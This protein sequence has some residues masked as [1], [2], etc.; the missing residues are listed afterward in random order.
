MCF[1]L[2]LFIDVPHL[3]CR[4]H[5]DGGLN[6]ANFMSKKTVLV[7]LGRSSYA[8]CITNECIQAHCNDLVAAKAALL[9]TDDCENR[10]GSNRCAYFPV[11]WQ[12]HLMPNDEFYTSE[13][14]TICQDCFLAQQVAQQ[15]AQQ[16]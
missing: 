11:C 13:S 15:V 3:S 5:L 14:D 2:H 9:E 16:L 4:L 1:T 8:L 6:A 12:L 10:E 7:S